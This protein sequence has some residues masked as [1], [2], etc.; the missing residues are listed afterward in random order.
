MTGVR[1]TSS[2]CLYLCPDAVSMKDETPMMLYLKDEES[3][4]ADEDAIDV[5]DLVI[6]IDGEV[7]VS[8]M[9]IIQSQRAKAVPKN[10]LA[11]HPALVGNV[12]SAVLGYNKTG[13]HQCNRAQHGRE[14]DAR[15]NAGDQKGGSETDRAEA[16]RKILPGVS[17]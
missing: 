13:T 9:F 7:V 5:G 2:A 14:H 12:H 6:T 10:I 4:G 15:D 8:G 16:D 17:L 11:P 3:R 1:A